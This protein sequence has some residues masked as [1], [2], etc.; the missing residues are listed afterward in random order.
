[1]EVKDLLSDLVNETTLYFGDPWRYKNTEGVILP[2]IARASWERNYVLLSEVQ[3]QVKI[4]D[5]GSISKLNIENN[6]D[7]NVLI[8]T[9]EMLR[10]ASTQPR[11][12]QRSAVIAPNK[13]SLIDVR[14]IQAS[15]PIVPSSSFTATGW[16]TPKEVNEVL[17]SS[18]YTYNRQGVVWQCINS[19]STTY[20]ALV[21][22][23]SPEL[24]T[25][26]SYTDS[27]I[28]AQKTLE[29]GLKVL[30]EMISHVPIHSKQVGAVFFKGD[31]LLGLE[32]F[33]SPDSWNAS[34]EA[35]IKK[36]GYNLTSSVDESVLDVKVRADVVKKRAKEFIR[37][38]IESS[39]HDKIETDL[40]ESGIM[41]SKD[42]VGEYVRMDDRVIYLVALAKDSNFK[43]SNRS[44]DW[45][46][47]IQD[48]VILTSNY[49]ISDD[50]YSIIP[51]DADIAI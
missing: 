11:T 50:S 48:T 49:S 27:L 24:A 38:I 26:L 3:D 41:E 9:G 33:D 22:A 5:T 30:N 35:A 18:G 39:I 36:Y 20:H 7:R 19:I 25:S 37:K 40:Y 13:K 34:Y 23:S 1:V 45:R 16:Y 21:S 15:H 6:S 4:T 29:S 32:M 14:C 47:P 10:G 8:R 51:D 28:D 2:I 46:A 42:I 43:S 44:T 12:F 31:K 17:L